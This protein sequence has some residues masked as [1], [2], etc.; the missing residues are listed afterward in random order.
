M[1]DTTAP[2]NILIITAYPLRLGP[3]EHFLKKRKFEVTIKTSIRDAVE[4]ITNGKADWTFLSVNLNVNLDRTIDVLRKSFNVVP[5]LFG[6]ESDSRTMTRLQ[7]FGE[8]A[9]TA[10]ATGPSIQFKIS[11]ITNDKV[12]LFK[13][14]ASGYKPNAT[15][16][17]GADLGH[18]ILRGGG[19]APVGPDNFR[20]LQNSAPNPRAITVKSGEPEAPASVEK[21]IDEFHV[22]ISELSGQKGYVLMGLTA[23]E[24]KKIQAKS[25]D[26]VVGPIKAAPKGS[27]QWNQLQALL[28]ASQSKGSGD[29]YSCFVPTANP[30]PA[31]EISD[32]DA[33]RL[34]V[35]LQEIPA[36]VAL[37]CPVYVHL[38]QNGKFICL[39][40]TAGVLTQTQ[41]QKLIKSGLKFLTI[42]TTDAELFSLFYVQEKLMALRPP[43]Q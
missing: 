30:L 5:I 43:P 2:V 1:S 10:T 8:Q 9:M 4:V 3:T 14:K 24:G 15:G 13:S 16:S 18:V 36:E 41:Q 17:S 12:E 35:P 11:Q 27:P 39:I 7:S 19:S 32:V 33:S 31:Y 21:P 26:K 23:D 22:V 40:K 20:P 42:V 28:K 34:N 25:T 29:V 37:P 6:D 38:P